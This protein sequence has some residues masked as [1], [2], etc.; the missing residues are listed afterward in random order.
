MR[1]HV[2]GVMLYDI[3]SQHL[4]IWGR[5]E[6]ILY[7]A[8]EILGIT[9]LSQIAILLMLYDILLTAAAKGHRQATAGLSLHHS[10][11]EGLIQRWDNR[12][13]TRRIDCRQLVII[14]DISQ[15]RIFYRDVL[16]H[17]LVLDLSEKHK[18]HFF[19]LV[20]ALF[21]QDL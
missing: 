10:L 20:C 11:S 19:P 1:Y 5:R 21:Y 15:V 13:I 16:Q 12:Y 18:M 3:G 2:L 17:S 14:S 7:A 6:R 4:G 8:G 9:V